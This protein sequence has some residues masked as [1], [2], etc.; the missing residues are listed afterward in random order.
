MYDTFITRLFPLPLR[1]ICG[2]PSR[3]GVH[4]V[5]VPLLPGRGDGGGWGEFRWVP[6]YLS[7]PQG[8]FHPRTYVRGVNHKRKSFTRYDLSGALRYDLSGALRYD[9]AGALRCDLAGA[10]YDLSG[11]CYDLSGACYDLSGALLYI[12][13]PFLFEAQGIGKFCSQQRVTSSVGQHTRRCCDAL[14]LGPRD[15][16]INSYMIFVMNLYIK[17]Y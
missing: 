13:Y 2:W 14:A 9:L 7:V 11:A 16:D 15:A 5:S 3:D 4:G 1:N 6:V 8:G 17:K 12:F 10:C